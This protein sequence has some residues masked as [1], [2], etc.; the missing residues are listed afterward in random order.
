MVSCCGDDNTS[1]HQ[2]T[3]NGEK[4]SL[5]N[6][7]F[8]EGQRIG[9]KERFLRKLSIFMDMRLPVLNNFQFTQLGGYSSD[10]KRESNGISEGRSKETGGSELNG[11]GFDKY[12]VSTTTDSE[13]SF[14]DGRKTKNSANSRLKIIVSRKKLGSAQQKT[15]YSNIFSWKLNHRRSS[16]FR[17]GY[18]TLVLTIFLIFCSLFNASLV[19][20]KGK[21]FNDYEFKK[22]NKRLWF[23]Y[24]KN[25]INIISNLKFFEE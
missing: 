16:P 6:S 2:T 15:S 1:T 4:E 24:L 12:I 17:L 7:R 22:E 8:L 23:C 19:S 13:C 18:S 25:K 9:V 20:V 10:V 5:I 11:N 3:S 14:I 21:N